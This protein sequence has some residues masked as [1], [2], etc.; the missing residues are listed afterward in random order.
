MK[1]KIP[2]ITYSYFQT[3][4]LSTCF[5]RMFQLMWPGLDGLDGPVLSGTGFVIKRIAL[6]GSFVKEG[7]ELIDYMNVC[8]CV[9]VCV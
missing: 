3:V 8:V 7:K 1:A 5:F 4:L 2:S 9:C 6:Y